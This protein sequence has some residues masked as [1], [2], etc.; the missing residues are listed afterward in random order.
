LIILSKLDTSANTFLFSNA[1]H[2]P[3]DFPHRVLFS[4]YQS[5]ALSS[6]N[7]RSKSVQT[8]DNGDHD[9]STF[10]ERLKSQGFVIHDVVGD[11]NCLFRTIADQIEGD[12]HQHRKYRQIAVNHL[13]KYKAHFQAFM[14]KTEDINSYLNKMKLDGT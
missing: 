5:T 10:T 9:I 3:T 11:G 6:S 12:E 7:N 2:L 13:A 8:T 4:E 14:D 1:I